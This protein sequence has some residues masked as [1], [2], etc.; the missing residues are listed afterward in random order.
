MTD[1]PRASGALPLGLVVTIAVICIVVAVLS[2]ARRADEVEIAQERQLLANAIADRGRRVLHEVENVAGG[3]EVLV[4]LEE[5]VD[6]DW[7]HRRIGLRL[8]TFFDHDNVFLIDASDRL[9]Y[10]LRGD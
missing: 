7:M 10:A 2:A 3:D 1:G 6:R 9:A 5:S 4:H 8:S